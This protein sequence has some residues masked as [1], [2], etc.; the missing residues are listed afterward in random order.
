MTQVN[1]YSKHGKNKLS[2]S[3]LKQIHKQIS[4]RD[5]ERV[6]S[7][8]GMEQ[9]EQNSYRQIGFGLF[10]KSPHPAICL[11]Y[12]IYLI[13]CGYINYCSTSLLSISSFE[14]RNIVQMNHQNQNIFV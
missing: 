14:I 9:S 12:I 6:G 10:I 11:L 2:D 4:T 8:L 1:F 5:G 7:E 3:A 13:F